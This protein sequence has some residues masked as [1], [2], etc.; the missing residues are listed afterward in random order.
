MGTPRGWG[1]AEGLAGLYGTLK[2]CEENA[3]S[4]HNGLKCI[5]S[6]KEER[7]TMANLPPLSYN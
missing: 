3:S 4:L 6:L 5:P 1:I 2:L 7:K